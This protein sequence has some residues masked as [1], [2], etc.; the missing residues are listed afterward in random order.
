MVEL[1]LKTITT[2]KA[3][4]HSVAVSSSEYSIGV[5]TLLRRLSPRTYSRRVGDRHQLPLA[6]N[7]RRAARSH[8]T[9]RSSRTRARGGPVPGSGRRGRG[10]D[11]RLGPPEP[12]NRRPM[13]ARAASESVCRLSDQVGGVSARHRLDEASKSSPFSEPRGSR[14]RRRRTSGSPPLV[15]ATL[16]AFESF[17]N[18][19]RSISATRS[20]R[21]RNS[22]KAGQAQRTASV[23]PHRERRP[24]RHRVGDVVRAEQGRRS[25]SIS[26]SY[27]KITPSSSETSATWLGAESRPGA[28]TPR[29]RARAHRLVAV[30]D[31]DI[32]VALVGE[33][34]QLR[35]EVLVEARV[36]VEVVGRELRNTAHS[37]ANASASSSWKLEHSQTIVASWGAWPVSEASG[38]HVLGHRDGSAASAGC[39]RSARSRSSCRSCRSPR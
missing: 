20:R 17:T 37:G 31:R 29:G 6:R 32:V 25:A 15:A 22:W 4:R 33:D 30:V 10:T 28:R 1:A 9:R 38:V 26:G 34:P 24:R 7:A 2:P 23:E 8:G 16:V 18:S 11:R 36:A 19:E 35:G 12:A 27:G 3:S 13:R 5:R 39:G 14:E 21:C